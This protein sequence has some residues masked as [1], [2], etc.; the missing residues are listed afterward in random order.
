MPLE[1]TQPWSNPKLVKSNPNPIFSICLPDLITNLY[2]YKTEGSEAFTIFHVSI[3][4]KYNIKT[5]LK[6]KKKKKT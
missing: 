5:N 3:I 2:I 1:L 6:K 4:F